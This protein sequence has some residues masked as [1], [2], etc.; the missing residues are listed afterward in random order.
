MN[1]SKEKYQTVAFYQDV[2]K[3][4]N[5]STKS[6]GKGE[7]LMEQASRA[8]PVPCTIINPTT[9]PSFRIKGNGGTDSGTLY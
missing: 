8:S 9:T 1:K 2:L 4:Y 3:E 7:Y 5:L 6:N